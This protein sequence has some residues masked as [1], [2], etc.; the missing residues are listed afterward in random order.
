MTERTR[1]TSRMTSRQFITAEASNTDRII[2]YREGLFWKAYERSAYALCSQIRPLK[3]TRK[4]LKNLGGGDLVSVGFPVASEASTIGSLSVI[5][6]SELR[7][8]VVTP[9]PI[10]ETAFRTWKAAVPVKPA[11]QPA[12]RRNDRSP[13]LPIAGNAVETENAVAGS[14][15]SQGVASTGGEAV[16]ASN[17]PSQEA[18]RST[19]RRL[20][21]WFRRSELRSTSDCAARCRI[22][23]ELRAFDL[24]EKTPLECM[25]F[26]AELK[27]RLS[28]L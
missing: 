13:E 8:V 16:A 20:L 17:L 23:R 10:D 25:Y 11:A 2:L 28:D 5:A 24:A 21:R 9:R 3:P 4:V 1:R 19:L 27:K 26:V 6:R 7:L 22:V 14:V 18:G 15:A 12:E